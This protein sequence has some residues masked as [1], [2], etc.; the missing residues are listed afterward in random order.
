MPQYLTLK[1]N[2]FYFRQG[3][4]AELRAL[5]GR[6]EIKKSLGHDYARAVS[7]CKRYAVAADLLIAEARLKL[8]S[9][10]VQPYSREGVRRTRPVPLTHVTPELEQE[11]ANLI[12]ESLLE[13]DR[14]RRIAGMEA[15]EFAAYGQHI[16]ASLGALRRQLAMGQVEPLLESARLALIGRGYVPEFSTDDW[17]RIAYVMTQASLEAYEDIAARHAGTVVKAHDDAILPSQ[18]ELQNTPKADAVAAHT[19][20]VTWQALYDVWIKECVRP[21]NTQAAYLAAMQL[22]NR[23]SHHKPLQAITREDTLAYRD[24]LRNEQG[25]APGTVANKIGFVGTLINAG[26][27]HARLAKYLPHNP[28]EDIKIK[29]SK[30]GKAGTRRMPFSDAELKLIFGSPIYA[31]G[32]RPAGG[33]GEAAAW[34]PAIAYLTGMRLEEIATLHVRQFHVDA[35]GNRYI[36]TEDGKNDNSTDRDVPLH[37]GLIAAGLLEFVQ[38]CSGRL[39]PKVDCTNEVLS[40]AFSQ[41]YG[42][43][44]DSLGI[45]AKSKVFHSFRHLF[46]DL[47]RNAGLD[48][49]AIDQICGHE[50]GTVGGK[51]GLGRRI[52]VLAELMARIVPP[53]A[54]P[55]I[56]V[57]P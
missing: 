44:L 2:T 47:C 55:F 3:V 43:Y 39:F 31:A 54:V 26:R 24:F 20:A 11:F 45:T 32:H 46:K 22:F 15:A 53:V 8:D 9:Q 57:K 40:K 50:P 17:R 35:L 41:W 12:R 14:N 34:I 18:F 27:N 25:L 23:F 56:P 4:P 7:E 21:A 29:Q 19:D 30:K 37:P 36:H 1:D 42:R 33:G 52:D 13:T 16:E 48:D 38:S 49:S 51:Y 28:F 5:I 6:R 10:P